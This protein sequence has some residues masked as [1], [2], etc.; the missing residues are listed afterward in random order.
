MLLATKPKAVSMTSRRDALPED[1]LLSLDHANVFYSPQYQ[2]FILDQ[3][4][5]LV[6]FHD[7]D[8]IVPVILTNKLIFRYAELCSDPFSISQSDSE[9]SQ[10]EFLDQVMQALKDKCGVM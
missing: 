1:F 8:F 2:R 3:K 7:H 6:Y 4:K 10:R 9:Q 5:Q